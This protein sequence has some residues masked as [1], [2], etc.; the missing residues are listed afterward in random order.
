MFK[1]RGIV[2]KLGRGSVCV[3]GGGGGGGGGGEGR[4]PSPRRA[5]VEMFQRLSTSVRQ[6]CE[7]TYVFLKFV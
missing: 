6:E 5:I 2:A 3:W 4:S 1:P 7:I